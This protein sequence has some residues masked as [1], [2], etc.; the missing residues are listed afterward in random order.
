M[1]LIQMRVVARGDSREL[2]SAEVNDE[3]ELTTELGSLAF[4]ALKVISGDR[5]AGSKRNRLCR[6]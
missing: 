3:E 1:K 2:T 6:P 4:R 5:T